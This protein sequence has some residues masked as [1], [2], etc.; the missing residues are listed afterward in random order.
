MILV[1][2]IFVNFFT[3]PGLTLI[4]NVEP[5]DLIGTFKNAFPVAVILG[6]MRVEVKVAEKVTLAPSSK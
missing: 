3:F 4:V 1:E 5:D 6:A 2:G